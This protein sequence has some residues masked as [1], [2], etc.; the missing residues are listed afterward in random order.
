ME[1]RRRE[2]LCRVLTPKPRPCAG[3]GSQAGSAP[4]STPQAFG[5]WKQLHVA[6]HSSK[7]PCR[8]H[9]G[10]IQLEK[11]YKKEKDPQI[12]N[13][14]AVLCAFTHFDSG[15]WAS[16]PCLAQPCA[17]WDLWVLTAAI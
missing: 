13:A 5:L 9:S 6:R 8:S 1:W 7:A 16:H 4:Q 14:H 10:K 2:V 11:A 15:D 17:A 3:W 12:L